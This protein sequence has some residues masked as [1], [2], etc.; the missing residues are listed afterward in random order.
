MKEGRL[1]SG[2]LVPGPDPAVDRRSPKPGAE[3]AAGIPAGKMGRAKVDRAHSGPRKGLSAARA[4]HLF[5]HGERGPVNAGICSKTTAAKLG[6]EPRAPFSWPRP[7]PWGG[8]QGAW[9][10]GWRQLRPAST[11]G[12]VHLQRAWRGP[13]GGFSE[14]AGF[15]ATASHGP[16]MLC[17]SL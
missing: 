2:S 16:P 12:S 6:Q 14:S 9:I 15:P 8:R 7:S 3:A 11:T 17:L 5:P 4:L 10:Q 13:E 1:L